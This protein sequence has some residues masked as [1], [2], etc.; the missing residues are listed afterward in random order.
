MRGWQ[1][2]TAEEHVEWEMLLQPPAIFGYRVQGS[3][4]GYKG[5]LFPVLSCDSD[6]WREKESKD[7]NVGLIFHLVRKL[8]A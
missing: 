5:T 8:N 2:H 3:V 4:G 6:L 1:G 7:G